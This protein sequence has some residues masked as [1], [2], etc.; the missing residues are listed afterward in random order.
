MLK[1]ISF[2]NNSFIKSF[3]IQFLNSLHTYTWKVSSLSHGLLKNIW[4]M[5][6]LYWDYCWEVAHHWNWR[7]I[8]PSRLCPPSGSRNPAWETSNIDKSFWCDTWTTTPHERDWT[9]GVPSPMQCISMVCTE[10]YTHCHT[11]ELQVRNDQAFYF[12]RLTQTEIEVL[13]ALPH[14]PLAPVI[15]TLPKRSGNYLLRAGPYYKLFGCGSLQ[16]QFEWKE[17]SMGRGSHSLT[18]D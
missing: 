13:E 7:E 6:R 12:G 5:C 4:T 2:I 15:Q 10:V 8:S 16:E 1:S 18:K 11:V 9:R 14:W 3:C 17:T